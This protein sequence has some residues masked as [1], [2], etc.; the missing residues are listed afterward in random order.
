MDQDDLEADYQELIDQFKSE[1]DDE[2]QINSAITSLNQQLEKILSDMPDLSKDDIDQLH[3]EALPSLQKQLDEIGA[4]DED[5]R[6]SRQLI[7]REWP[8]EDKSIQGAQRLI[9][10]II[11]SEVDLLDKFKAKE[12]QERL[13]EWLLKV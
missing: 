12:E 1:A 10:Q 4:R 5:S 11:V 3:R 2:Q 6:K 13:E 9:N 7:Q 8:S